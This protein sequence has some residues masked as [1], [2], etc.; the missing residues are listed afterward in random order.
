MTGFG[1]RLCTRVLFSTVAVFT[2][3]NRYEHNNSLLYLFRLFWLS[4]SLNGVLFLNYN[5]ENQK[6]EKK[7]KWLIC[8]K[9]SFIVF[10]QIP[11]IWSM[12][13][14]FAN[15]NLFSIDHTLRSTLLPGV[16]F[17]REYYNFSFYF[18]LLLICLQNLMSGMNRIKQ[19]A[20][21]S[22]K[23]TVVVFFFVFSTPCKCLRI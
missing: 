15:E 4:L 1:A 14:K 21:P 16:V 8:S 9:S 22:G 20:Y 18:I 7:I 12:K 13:Q 17:N 3:S 19:E 5:I 23:F 11:D 2:F 10:H 6:R